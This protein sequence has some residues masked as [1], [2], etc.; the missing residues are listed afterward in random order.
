MKPNPLTQQPTSQDRTLLRNT[1]LKLTATQKIVCAVV[2]IAV[3]LIW[4]DLLNRLIAFGNNID[5]DG[6]HALGVQAV[7]LLKQYNPF[8]WWAVV[9]LCTLIIAYFLY[10]FVRGTQ[11][12][13]RARLVKEETVTLLASQLSEPARE[14]LRW[15]WQD[16]RDPISV[17]DLQRAY[18]EMRNGRAAKITL[19]RRH[20]AVLGVADPLPAEP[21][22]RPTPIP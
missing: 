17:G 21:E 11:R 1:L 14:V 4:Y 12:T 5:Y 9:A 22:A 7:N 19:A 8:F 13:V 6:L 3:V 16:R 15:A 2:I 10:G 18:A 20:A